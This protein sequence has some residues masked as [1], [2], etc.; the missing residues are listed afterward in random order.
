MMEIEQQNLYG[1]SGIV[2]M[3]MIDEALSHPF[4]AVLLCTIDAGAHIGRHQHPNESLLLL[5]TEGAGAIEVDGDI[6][7]MRAGGVVVVPRAATL[8]IENTSSTDVMTYWMVRGQS[9][10]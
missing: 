10:Q 8:T 7:E 6:R 5:C 3:K 2:W 9:Q 1:G 4:K